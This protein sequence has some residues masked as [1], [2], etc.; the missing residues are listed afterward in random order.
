MKRFI[1]ILKNLN[2]SEIE[3][4]IEF[5]LYE[6]FRS[7]VHSDLKDNLYEET[8]EFSRFSTGISFFFFNGVIDNHISS[9][10][11]MKKIKENITFFEKRQVPFLW[12]LGP[13]STPKKMGELLIKNGFIINKLQGMA[14]NL[15][16]LNTERELLNKVEII[17]IESM[18]ALKVWNDIILTGFDFPKEVRSDFFFEAFSFI[19]L[20]DRASASAFLAY[21]DGNPVASSLVLYKAGVAGIHLVTTLEEARG[22]GIGTA[23]TLAPLNEAKKL[24]YETAILHS[25]E[26]GLNMYKRMGF[27]EYCTIE[28]FIWQPGSKE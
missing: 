21:Y 7:M 1:T 12:V 18:N 26:M 6:F 15:K 27:K 24:G 20:K 11:A 14:Y 9:E 19:L 5:N 4:A 2:Q 13:S 28:L 3:H 8:K 10:N 22:K 23:I 25:T 17:K 16:I